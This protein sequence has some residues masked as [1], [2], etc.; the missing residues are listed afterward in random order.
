MKKVRFEE[1]DWRGGGGLVMWAP[2]DV[3]AREREG[4]EAPNR[5]RV[6]AEDADREKWDGP[7]G[8]EGKNCVG[9]RREGG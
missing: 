5:E 6:L 3:A 4:G 7:M 8:G 9:K 2:A 1:G